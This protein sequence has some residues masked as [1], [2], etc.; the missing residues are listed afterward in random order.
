MLIVCQVFLVYISANPHSYLMR[1]SLFCL[2]FKQI[3][4]LKSEVAKIIQLLSDR[5]GGK[6][7]SAWGQTAPSCL[8]DPVT[9]VHGSYTFIP[10]QMF[11]QHMLCARQCAEYIIYMTSLN[12]TATM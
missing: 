4:K 9:V 10:L 5:E 3:R 6:P 8:P 1:W 2:H 12:L 11:I 7:S